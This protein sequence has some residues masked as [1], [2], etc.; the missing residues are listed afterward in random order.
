VAQIVACRRR[1]FGSPRSP[2][3]I[4]RV[5]RQPTTP[6]GSAGGRPS[7]TPAGRAVTATQQ[8]R[9]QRS[10]S[11][12][13]HI[14]HQALSGRSPGRTRPAATSSR[15]CRLGVMTRRLRGSGGALALTSSLRRER[16]AQIRCRFR[17]TSSDY[18]LPFA[19]SWRRQHQW[20]QVGGG[21]RCITKLTLGLR[22]WASR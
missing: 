20:Q 1:R 19:T 11:V 18:Q 12:R 6:S 15:E 21:F 22:V 8:C 9:R 7:D 4:S 3:N 10:R 14:D 2:L 5:R 17:S 13:R 16:P